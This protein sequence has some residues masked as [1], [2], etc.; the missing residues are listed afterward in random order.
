MPRG[1]SITQGYPL[2]PR[3]G[4]HGVSF[5]TLSTTGSICEILVQ[6]V[7]NSDVLQRH[8][9][10]SASF[11]LWLGLARAN[12]SAATAAVDATAVATKPNFLAVHDV[13]VI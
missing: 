7:Q 12:E 8:S 4:G 11:E 3:R 1:R 6:D 2:N 9:G 5:R 13:V 10:P